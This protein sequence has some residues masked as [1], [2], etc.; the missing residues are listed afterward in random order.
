ML[1][2]FRLGSICFLL[3]FVS[4]GSI[5]G[6]L[7]KAI[8]LARRRPG[9][10]IEAV[11][12]VIVDRVSGLYGLLF[13]VVIAGLFLQPKDV[14]A[15][16][17]ILLEMQAVALLMFATGTA[18]L[19]FLIL[20]G[21]SVDRLLQAA[22]SRRSLGRLIARVGSPLR[23]FHAYPKVFG[24]SV[25]LSMIVQSLFAL[26]VYLI[27]NSL[28]NKVPTL[29]EHFVI[30]PLGKLASAVPITPGGIGVWEAAIDALYQLI[31]SQT[32][33]ASGTLIAIVFEMLNLLLALIGVVFYW[34]ANEEVRESLGTAEETP[35]VQDKIPSEASSPKD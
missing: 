9:K 20:G 29:T 19:L 3:S 13:L 5:G 2:A 11:A 16:P 12:S 27:A 15:S 17:T 34:T 28:Y 22:G 18:V 1:E 14:D 35:E 6:D 4:V 32:T 24:F 25:I 10:R 33:A 26:S 31:P 23:T 8:F 30:V 21:Q 7:F